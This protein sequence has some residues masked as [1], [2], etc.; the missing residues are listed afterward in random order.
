MIADI[1]KRA[2]H[3]SR[4]LQGQLRGLEK[5]IDNEDYC[6]DIVTQSL[7]IQNSLRSLNKLVVE[8]HLR[9]HITDMFEAGG[10]DREAAVSELLRVFELTNNRGS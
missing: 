2:L 6:V 3:R 9:T 1:K 10:D 7:A 4:I 5:M 8:N